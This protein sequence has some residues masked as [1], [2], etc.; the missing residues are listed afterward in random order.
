MRKDNYIERKEMNTLKERI[1]DYFENNSSQKTLQPVVGLAGVGKSVMLQ[2]LVDD[3]GNDNGYKDKFLCRVDISDCADE[4][5][6]YLKIATQLKLY[7]A[8]NDDGESPKRKALEQFMT[9]HRWI[10]GSDINN[11]EVNLSN[12][13]S[14]DDKAIISDSVKK[15]L[16][17]IN[18]YREI[19]IDTNDIVEKYEI[20]LN[21][22]E[23]VVDVIPYVHLGKVL[24]ELVVNSYEKY[25]LK[26]LLEESLE[27]ISNKI[28][29]ECVLRELLINAIPE[30]PQ[31]NSCSVIV[32]DNFQLNSTGELGRDHT[33]LIKKEGLIDSIDAYWI[34]AGRS[35]KLGEVTINEH[36]DDIKEIIQL[37][38]FNYE[39]ACT[40]IEMRTN[41]FFVEKGVSSDLKKEVMEKILSVC[42]ITGHD[43]VMNA[44]IDGNQLF[45]PPYLL[46][47]VVNHFC[48]LCKDPAYNITADSFVGLK[49]KEEFI[50][51]YFYKDLSDLMTNAFQI[52]SCLTTWDNKWIE[53]VRERFDNHLLN[54]KTVLFKSAPMEY[55]G[56]DRFKLHEGIR[57]GLF[58]V[59]TNYI[60]YDV[61]KYLYEKFVEVYENGEA[62]AHKDFW[63]NPER[64]QT[65]ADCVY[66]YIELMEVKNKN[67]FVGIQKAIENIYNANCKRG[68]V[69]DSF[70]RF[71]SKYID[72]YGKTFGIPFVTLENQ[73]FSN[74][75]IKNLKEHLK[76]AM[77]EKIGNK[78]PDIKDMVYFMECCFRL[79]DMYTNINCS[80][81]AY[82][83]EGLGIIFWENIVEMIPENKKD[84]A[85]WKCKQQLA[86]QINAYAYD[87]S[88]EHNYNI[89]YEN[90]K[91][92]LQLVYDTTKEIINQLEEL[93]KTGDLKK[94]EDLNK[95]DDDDKEILSIFVYPEK[96]SKF[97][98]SSY[99]EINQETFN[100]LKRAYQL[101]ITWKISLDEK[102]KKGDKHIYIRSVL[103]EMLL[104]EYLK[105]RGNFPWYNFNKDSAELTGNKCVE[106]GVRTYWMRKAVAE[107]FEENKC[108]GRE[109]LAARDNMI[110]SYHNVCVYLYKAGNLQDACL[111]EH[112]VIEEA[113]M[114]LPVK[115]NFDLEVQ[116]RINNIQNNLDIKKKVKDIGDENKDMYYGLF[117]YLWTQV[118]GN[119]DDL[120][121]IQMNNRL[122]ECMQYMGDYYLH[123]KYYTLAY[124]KLS[125]VALCRYIQF[126]LED[127][128]TLD[129]L[130]RLYVLAV[131][132]DASE[133]K[134][135]IERCVRK[136][137]I[138]N[139]E[140]KKWN[141][142]K[143][144]LVS[145]INCL[146]RLITIEKNRGENIAEKLL[147][148][149]DE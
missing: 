83:L 66:Q 30:D 97:G 82:N 85:Y 69:T 133:C 88:Q 145:K 19:N 39:Q 74:N 94:L 68:V 100:K 91:T 37:Q 49:T 33:W 45:Y 35:P 79:S 60:K 138:E 120:G 6:I 106:F 59:S 113:N 38:G 54:A 3:L 15:I 27:A 111:L 40:Y 148:E 109:I 23:P 44:E 147:V 114:F 14:M 123:M 61:L 48:K 20:F 25:E 10:Y 108:S 112:E 65:F 36:W 67:Y 95:F 73:D 18:D 64:L 78:L 34:I 22:L 87:N 50:G 62:N 116:N 56:G 2:R 90:C 105:L 104:V 143:Q 137:L 8:K 75:N 139:P 131:I 98:I 102:R 135:Q 80:T 117:E 142:I 128:K 144:G 107:V 149:L 63:Y 141:Y 119:S 12:I 4:I 130:L 32:I 11:S 7:Y 57:D 5:E 96:N 129:S 126:G 81:T 42:A 26:K 58:N 115:N 118:I 52:L 29:R 53:I 122:S 89:A 93:G 55:L 110:N 125:Q 84:G 28:E 13:M 76:D 21:I 9:I 134:Q 70:I 146:E 121:L 43:F 72:N 140:R 41:V 132:Q 46:N 47:L 136:N 124:K 17:K 1:N 71:Y 101:L 24:V 77:K 51:Y 99:R 86:K 31:K 127:N 92:G 16:D 103:V